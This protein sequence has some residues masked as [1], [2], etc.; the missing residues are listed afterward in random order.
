MLSRRF[1]L[2]ALLALAAVLAV[3]APASAQESSGDDRPY[4]RSITVGGDGALFADNDVAVFRFGVTTRRRSAGRALRANS[5]TMRRITTA[6]RAKGVQ[7][8][9]IRTDVVSLDRASV[10]TKT[11]YVARNGVAVTIRDLDQAGAIVD[12]GVR[13][14]ATNVYGPEFGVSNAEGLYRDALGLAL[15]DAR[16]KA[17]RM[18]REAGVALGPVLRIR[19]GSNDYED[20]GRFT[21]GDDEG[22]AG[23]EAPIAPG[24]TQISATVTVTFAVS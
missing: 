13:G 10:K 12:V 3:A 22:A 16:T 9:D 14:G 21:S 11:H 19:E 2:A 17:E 23:R 4:E 20:G 1:A 24:R 8:S 18:A 5:A 6:I 7:P 15:A